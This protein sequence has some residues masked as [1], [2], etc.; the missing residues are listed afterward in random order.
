VKGM[1]REAV[2]FIQFKFGELKISEASYEDLLSEADEQYP[3]YI[4]IIGQS[5]FNTSRQHIEV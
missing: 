5:L 3:K 4:E 2:K 1:S